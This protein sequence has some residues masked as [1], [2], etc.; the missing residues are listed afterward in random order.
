MTTYD[1]SRIYKGKTMW[2]FQHYLGGPPEVGL[3]H[4]GKIV[5]QS[6]QPLEGILA[7]HCHIA[8]HL[9]EAYATDDVMDDDEAEITRF[10]QQNRMNVISYAEAM[11]ENT[12]QWGRVYNESR[13]KV[14]FIKRTPPFRPLFHAE[15]SETQKACEVSKPCSTDHISHQASK[16]VKKA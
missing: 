4:R 15:L 2:L 3:Q 12:L 16:R 13:V 11:W 5:G 8:N 1:S 7:T 6:G 14:I 9:L 10:C